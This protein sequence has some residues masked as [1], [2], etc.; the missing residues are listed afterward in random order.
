MNEELMA[1][2]AKM[3]DLYPEAKPTNLIFEIPTNKPLKDMFIKWNRDINYNHVDNLRKDISI[4]GQK[5]PG[6]MRPDGKLS[7]C[8][9]RYVACQQ[10]GIPIKVIMSDD[11]REDI[12]SINQLNLGWNMENWMNS[13]IDEDP[14]KYSNYVRFKK[15]LKDTKHEINNALGLVLNSET[16]GKIYPNR[17]NIQKIF[18]NGE[19]RVD[20]EGWKK[21]EDY[22]EKINEIG[23]YNRDIYRKKIFVLAYQKALNTKD[24]DHDRMI[25]KISVAP[26]ELRPCT[27]SKA[28]LEMLQGIYNRNL[29]KDSR[30]WLV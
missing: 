21:A 29:H 25:K 4:R 26:Y 15:F 1:I 5:I 3:K 23:K 17:N 16:M 9:H 28:Y 8:Q 19:L 6:N 13:Y 14:I 24:F 2:Y 11:S 7:E 18:K 30:V 27:T 20:E 12:T 10:L 22:A